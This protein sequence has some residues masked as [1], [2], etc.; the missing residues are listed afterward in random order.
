MILTLRRTGGFAGI[1]ETLGTLDT[2]SLG[3]EAQRAF[4]ARLKE[5]EQLAALPAH[6]ADQFHYELDIREPGQAP[7]TLTIVDEGD[8]DLP[9][10]RA[11]SALMETLG[12]PVP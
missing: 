3:G 11:L 1:Q 10:M 5:L 2:A 7:R 4:A 8:P 6:G 12:L 9:A